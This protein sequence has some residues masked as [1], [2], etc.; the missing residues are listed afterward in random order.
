[1][2]EDKKTLYDIAKDEIQM[3]IKIYLNLIEI[4]N[5]FENLSVESISSREEITILLAGKGSYLDPNTTTA[6]EAIIEW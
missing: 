3:Q 4:T 6:K 5:N 1:M 2:Y